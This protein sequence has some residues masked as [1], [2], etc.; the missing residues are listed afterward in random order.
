MKHPDYP[1]VSSFTDNR[2]KTRWRFRKTGFRTVY[3]PGEPH[4]KPFDDAYQAAIEGR[5]ARLRAEVVRMP[6]A[7]HPASLKA[8]WRL[9]QETAKWKALD[10]ES[11]SLYTRYI[12]EYLK[13]PLGT[14]T[15]GDGPVA[16]FKPRHVAAALD[17]W[18]GTPHKARILLVM[19][20]K[21]MRVA[22]R[23]EWIQ[24]DPTY[25][26]ERPVTTTKGKAAWPPHVCA[27]FERH[28]PIGSAPRTAYELAKWLGTR[29]S[30]V[31]SIRWDQL[32]TEIIDGEAVEGFKFIQHKGRNRQ[33][34]FAKFHPISP[35]LAEALAPLSR[36]TETVLSK[37]DGQP[38]KIKSM[39]TMMWHWRKAAGI[40]SGYSLHG[41]RH[42]MGGLLADA[43]ATAHQSR[44]VLGHATMAEVERYAKS[45][46]QAKT[47]TAGM[48]AVVRLV[49]G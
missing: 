39:T 34:A 14:M 25:G 3:L 33:N 37:P 23:E 4:T 1:G 5:T 9:L 43:G 7:S 11:R 44:D 21:L 24:Y 38:Y 6:G 22:I 47:A 49:R 29:R 32:V 31:A 13:T 18:G 30:D 35:M 20:Q 2:G 42:A 27:Q 26:A 10:P 19:L 28:W 17:A 46:N 12:E 41:L 45:R 16:D 40:K 36:E 8:A 15:V 48:K